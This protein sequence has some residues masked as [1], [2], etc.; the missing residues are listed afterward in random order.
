MIMMITKGIN[1]LGGVFWKT[2]MKRIK[3]KCIS[4]EKDETTVDTDDYL[5]EKRGSALA[6]LLR[7]D[8]R[9]LRNV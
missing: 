8:L 6:F 4:M 5:Q 1:E 7:Y 2:G 3:K 9:C